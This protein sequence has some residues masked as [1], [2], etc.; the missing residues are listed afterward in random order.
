MTT[1]ALLREQVVWACARLYGRGLNHPLSGN[2]SARVASDRCVIKPRAADYETLRPEDLAEVTLDGAH[3]SGMSPSTET[4]VHLA[5]YRARPDVQCV[6]HAHPLHATALAALRR[7]LPTVLDETVALFGGQVEVAE[8]AVSGSME[9]AERAARALHDR[10]AVLLAN[11][12]A[13][14]VG[15]TVREAVIRM[16][17]LERASATYL[18]ALGAGEPVPLPP[19]AVEAEL[20]IYRR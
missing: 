1:D 13:V 4:A 18:A 8:Y 7:P 12:G 9:L 3:L 5:I 11:H 2:V 10:G 15:R 17:V 16:E 14:T 19:E 6:A 20:R